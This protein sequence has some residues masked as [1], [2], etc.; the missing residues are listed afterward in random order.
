[1]SG[2]GVFRLLLAYRDISSG[3]FYCQCQR[4]WTTTAGC[5]ASVC[6]GSEEY[7]WANLNGGIREQPS[8]ATRCLSCSKD[9]NSFSPKYSQS[10]RVFGC[11][12][13]GF[14]QSQKQ[15]LANLFTDKTTSCRSYIN[16]MNI[17][18]NRPHYPNFWLFLS[19]PGRGKHDW[20]RTRKSTKLSNICQLRRGLFQGQHVPTGLSNYPS[21]VV[22]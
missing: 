7:T 16:W 15:Q 19:S 14:S 4:G 1:M 2:F 17:F 22:L 11:S 12:P 18:E 8:L 20:E 9:G 3:C 21:N 6:F 5:Q 13:G 10:H